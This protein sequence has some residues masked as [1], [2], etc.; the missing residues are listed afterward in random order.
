[1]RLYFSEEFKFEN[2]EPDPEDNLN[3]DYFQ[4]RKGDKVY[5]FDTNGSIDYEIE[6]L[7]R[8]WYKIEGR[9][10]GDLMTNWVWDDEEDEENT[11]IEISEEEFKEMLE[12]GVEDFEIGLVDAESGVNCE[13][14]KAKYEV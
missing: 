8:K 12:S 1:M 11:E 2:G 14:R 13:I 5:S 10:K 9:I 4:F 6:K 7:G 3:I